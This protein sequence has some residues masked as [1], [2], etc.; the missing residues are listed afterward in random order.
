MGNYLRWIIDKSLKA[1]ASTTVDNPLTPLGNTHLHDR[2]PTH[3]PF[4]RYVTWALF[5]KP[6]YNQVYLI[7][8]GID[9]HT[10]TQNIKTLFESDPN[11]VVIY[12]HQNNDLYT[13]KYAFLN[14]A[15]TWPVSFQALYCKDKQYQPF[16]DSNEQ[17]AMVWLYHNWR[18][19]FIKTEPINKAKLMHM[20]KSTERWFNTRHK[21]SPDEMDPAEYNIIT[22]YPNRCYELCVT[23]IISD[24]FIEQFSKIV[25]DADV[26]EM[27]FTHVKGF[28]STFLDAKPN[29]EWFNHISNFHRTG[30]VHPWFGE[31]LLS[32]VFL[33][34]ELPNKPLG[35]ESM[36]YK[37]LI[38]DYAR[39]QN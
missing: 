19:F 5:R 8:P 38:D 14:Q 7:N 28:H 11:G 2:V 18:S 33:L 36:T 16:N 37:E 31:H 21:V 39:K 4:N 29:K 12:I 10:R 20:F 27:D 32:K 24:N 15:K 17:R 26:G 30:D 13:E 9:E 23:D 1:T 6:N 34:H 35:W 3:V 22:E 25:I